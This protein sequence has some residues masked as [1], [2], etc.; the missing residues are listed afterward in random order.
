MWVN[1]KNICPGHISHLNEKKKERKIFS[2]MTLFS[3]QLRAFKPK[4]LITVLHQESF[5]VI[6]IILNS[7]LLDY[8]YHNT[9]FLV[10]V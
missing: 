8:Q 2:I 10:N 6:T 5:F 4:I 9:V 7:V 3:C 1:V